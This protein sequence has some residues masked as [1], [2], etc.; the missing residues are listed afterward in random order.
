MTLQ[1]LLAV[2]IAAA[3]LT[4]DFPAIPPLRTRPAMRLVTG[5][6]PGLNG[7]AARFAQAVV[8]VVSGDRGIQ[9]L[10][11]WTTTTVYAD[12][13]RRSHLLQQTTPTDERR[14]RL[15]AQV[16]SVH[17]SL[18][19]DGVAEVSIH[20]RQGQR[21]RAIA[22]RIELIERRWRCTVLDFGPA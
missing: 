11:S 17:V 18:P 22:A 9:Q 21:S 1:Q 2:P 3:Q 19:A 5:N 10:M 13:Q 15:R 4:L 14:R 16:R 12:L 6:S 20:V 7:F 8:E